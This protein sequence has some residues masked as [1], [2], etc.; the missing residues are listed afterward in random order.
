MGRRQL[1]ELARGRAASHWV[2]PEVGTRDFDLTSGPFGDGPPSWPP[3]DS[4]KTECKLHL[5]PATFRF[6]PHR[7]CPETAPMKRREML[8]SSAAALAL[9]QF[10]VGWATAA[11]KPKRKILF[12]TKSGG[13]EHSCIRR[14]G[15]KPSH[16]D[17]VLTDLGKQHNFEVVASKDGRLFDSDMSEFDAFFFQTQGDLLTVGNDKQPAMSTA[18]KKRLLDAVASGKGFLAARTAALTLA[19]R[20]GTM[21]ANSDNDRPRLIPTSPWSAAS[22][23]ATARNRFRDRSS[24]ARRSQASLVLPTKIRRTRSSSMTSGTR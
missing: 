15:D 12:F 21:R 20:R 2:N 16:A 22:S 13:F 7:T 19:T 14:K 6:C 1:A 11:D 18:G 10:P 17:Q 4:P 3:L 23:S 5:L 24:S 8:L 9:S